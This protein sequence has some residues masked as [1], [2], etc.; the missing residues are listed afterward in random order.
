MSKSETAGLFRRGIQL[1]LMLCMAGAL[2]AC[3]SNPASSLP[4]EVLGQWY[5]VGSSGGIDGNR[6]TEEATGYIVLHA[7]R[8]DMHNEEGAVTRQQVFFAS[9]GKTIYSEKDLWILNFEAAEA[10]VVLVSPDGQMMSLS[11]NAYDSIGHNY[12]R[13]R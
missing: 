6:G 11:P 10:H 7:D 1:S 3:G 4:E 9:R 8:L 12:S 2:V 5:F 13:A